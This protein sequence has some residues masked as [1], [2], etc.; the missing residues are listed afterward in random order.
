MLAHPLIPA[1]GSYTDVENATKERDL[2]SFG[3]SASL[4]SGD[5]QWEFEVTRMPKQPQHVR[6][7][8]EC[9]CASWSAMYP[10]ILISCDIWSYSAGVHS[11]LTLEMAHYFTPFFSYLTWN[12]WTCM[13]RI[14]P[15]MWL[16]TCALLWDGQHAKWRSFCK[17]MLFPHSGVSLQCFPHRSG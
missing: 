8:W 10:H 7:I 4:V 17:W 16:R 3:L 2:S 12:T 14:S 15:T 5:N 13:A 9:V 11:L 1:V 6:Q